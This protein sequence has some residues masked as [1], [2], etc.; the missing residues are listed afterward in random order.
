MLCRRAPGD[1]RRVVIRSHAGGR[2]RSVN[3]EGEVSLPSAATKGLKLV[4]GAGL[5]SLMPALIAQ[6]RTRQDPYERPYLCVPDR[7]VQS[8]VKN[9]VAEALGVCMNYELTS[10]ERALIGI[11]RQQGVV[12][13]VWS[14]LALSRALLVALVE[15]R[16]EGGRAW[17]TLG[18]LLE[19]VAPTSDGVEHQPPSERSPASRERRAYRFASHLARLLLGYAT[20]HPGLLESWARDDEPSSSTASSTLAWQAD[21][22]RR[23]LRLASERGVAMCAPETLVERLPSTV[24]GAPLVVFGYAYLSPLE[25]HI[26][27]GLSSR[28]QVTCYLD[29]VVRDDERGAAPS[30]PLRRW[31]APATVTSE[32]LKATAAEV[33]T[34]P[35]APADH[36][37]PLGRLRVCLATPGE[38]P[39]DEE[40][41]DALVVVG[42][43][44][45][46]REAEVVADHVWERLATVP[47]QRLS[48]VAVY[49][50]QYEAQIPW[51]ED[52]FAA[53]HRLLHSAPH[54]GRSSRLLDVAVELLELPEQGARRDAVLAVL[55]HACFRGRLE[56]GS[57]SGLT[58]AAG[59]YLGLDGEDPELRYLEGAPRFHWQ[60]G[61]S[62]LQLGAL[63]EGTTAVSVNGVE[64]VST[65][66]PWARDD[67]QQLHAWASSL[68]SDLHSLRG[69]KLSGA[70]WARVLED[71][72]RTYLAPRND[73]DGTHWAALLA[74]VRALEAADRVAPRVTGPDD[75]PLPAAPDDAA[76][77]GY[78]I[79]VEMVRD[80]LGTLG[81]AKGQFLTNGV[82][83]TR[84]VK[85]RGVPFRSVF[86]SGLGEGLYPSRET[87]D[88]LDVR[89]TPGV[90]SSEVTNRQLKELA[91]VQSVLSAREQLVLSWTSKDTAKDAP[92]APSPL[93]EELCDVMPAL[94]PLRQPL[95]AHEG[96]G[97]RHDAHAARRADARALRLELD[98]VVEEKT[99]APAAFLPSLA[100]WQE[101]LSDEN[102][103]YR[104]TGI[105]PLQETSVGEGPLKTVQRLSM[106]DLK[107]FLQDPIEAAAA[108]LGLKGWNINRDQ[109]ALVETEPFTVEKRARWLIARDVLGR[110]FFEHPSAAPSEEQVE[111]CVLAELA[112]Q[113][114]AG[115][116]PHGALLPPDVF[117]YLQE[118][119]FSVVTCLDE[120]GAFARGYDGIIGLGPGK[121]RWP[122]RRSVR[123]LVLDVDDRKVELTSERGCVFGARDNRLV[124]EL[125]GSA[126]P[127][128][129]PDADFRQR[130]ELLLLLLADEIEENTVVRAVWV[131]GEGK[132]SVTD[133][134]VPTRDDARPFLTTLIRA[135]N[136]PE[137]ARVLPLDALDD[138]NGLVELARAPERTAERGEAYRRV[139]GSIARTWRHREQEPEAYEGALRSR[140]GLLPPTSDELFELIAARFG[141]LV[142]M[143]GPR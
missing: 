25:R 6:L 39:S 137:H 32:A 92:L 135:M 2:C 52:R 111:E 117:E 72:V 43:P 127:V 7:E 82:A 17:D 62:R 29:T 1:W 54:G 11:A 79:A 119:V 60:Q 26:V 139:W 53:Q 89:G 113:Q 61:L 124:V 37:S 24:S 122:G 101:T 84:L 131:T 136:D 58:A 112:A 125:G 8:W 9:Q 12:D 120:H 42:A 105:R 108:R 71:V 97:L 66:L 116:L 21:L 44:G 76:P 78:A 140:N 28:M 129:R 100:A 68:L 118:R 45:A 13:E 73:S 4:L 102:R 41:G 55:T 70:A 86:I 23:A 35:S 90:A 134:R 10:V 47:D 36:R 128:R 15:E 114:A 14:P 56:A 93:I 103:L 16:S 126:N 83:V 19:P 48:D 74:A 138:L 64:L 88:P 22:W 59:I 142:D 95:T 91:F 77:F 5:S 20:T 141:P 107:A 115:A 50:A 69:W 3:S 106:W 75:S 31:S 81:G 109:E 121:T 143:E 123:P 94:K 30:V 98:D 132:P 133:Y 40:L 27:R 38:D 130:I 80:Q 51:L 67:V 63:M 49:S 65:E 87:V 110:C 34:L 99:G 33:T 57:Y 85:N 96:D 18:P 104:R 46:R